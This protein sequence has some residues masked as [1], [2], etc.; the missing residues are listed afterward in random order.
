MSTAPVSGQEI[1]SIPRVQQSVCPDGNPVPLL[2]CAREQIKTFT[3]PRTRDGKPDL[4]GYWGGTQVPH[5]SLE[6]HPRTLDDTGGPSFVVDPPDGKVPIQPWAE[7]QRAENFA[8]YIDHNGQCFQ[9]GVPRHLYM[10][11]AHQ[12]IQTPTRLVMLS[13]EANAYRIVILDGRPHIGRDIV[14]WQGDSRGRWEGDTL[15]VETTNQNGRAWLDQRGRFLT[16]AAVVVERFTLFEK[17]SIL[18]EIT[19]TDPLVY[20]RPFTMVS[21][22]R[23]NRRPGFEIWE[24]SCYE[25]EATAN[26]LRG[27]GLG[28]HPGIS[29]R[30]A[31]MHK[32]AYEQAISGRRAR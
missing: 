7:A 21:A 3:P 32:E 23:R 17:D 24:E 12:F 4:S 26:D 18:W 2:A 27:L 13:E 14:L 6:A 5:E 16:D 19:I 28:T 15:V 8:K 22:L 11:S 1:P 30:E 9:S 25:G 10:T 29:S 31:Q 20:T